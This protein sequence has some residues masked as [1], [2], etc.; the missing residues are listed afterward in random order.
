MN[1]TSEG[2][3]NATGKLT[4]LKRGPLLARISLIIRSDDIEL[5]R[6]K[7]LHEAARDMGILRQTLT[8]AHKNEKSA[9]MK[10]KGGVKVLYVEW[11]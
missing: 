5:K 11:L 7:S 9:I 10:C 3:P 2:Q 8:Y 6:Q 1:K 4:L